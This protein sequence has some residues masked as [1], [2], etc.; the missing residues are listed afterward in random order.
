M[1]LKQDTNENQIEFENPAQ[2][3][4]RDCLL[5]AANRV[6][7]ETSIPFEQPYIKQEEVLLIKQLFG[8]NYFTPQNS[9]PQA[10]PEEASN[11]YYYEYLEKQFIHANFGFEVD[12]YTTPLLQDIYDGAQ[13]FPCLVTTARTA[14]R[15]QQ[16][17]AV[18]QLAEIE[19][20]IEDFRAV[21]YPVLPA[22]AAYRREVL[23][24]VEKTTNLPL[25]NI[26][27][28]VSKYRDFLKFNPT[29][30]KQRQELI[31]DPETLKNFDEEEGV[32]P[33]Q[34]LLDLSG[35]KTTEGAGF[36]HLGRK[37]IAATRQQDLYLTLCQNTKQ[38]RI[39]Q[40]I[41]EVRGIS[42]RVRSEVQP[43]L[44]EK[45]SQDTLEAVKGI[46]TASGLNHRTFLILLQTLEHKLDKAN[47]LGTTTRTFL[48]SL[49]RP[50]LAKAIE[51]LRCCS[52]GQL[53]QYL[54]KKG[55]DGS[56]KEHAT[57]QR[58]GGIEAV[59]LA[60]QNFV[61]EEF[62]IQDVENALHSWSKA[63]VSIETQELL[64]QTLSLLLQLKGSEREEIYSKILN[65]QQ[66][67]W[68][69][70][71]S[72]Y[73]LKLKNEDKKPEIAI[74]DE[75]VILM[76]EHLIILI[77]QA[78]HPHN[79]GD[80][81]FTAGRLENIKRYCRGQRTNLVRLRPSIIQTVETLKADIDA[82]I[83]FLYYLVD[84]ANLEGNEDILDL[85]QVF[86]EFISYDKIFEYL[87]MLMPFK[88]GS[89][90][91]RQALEEIQAQEG[92]EVAI[93]RSKMIKTGGPS[94]KQ[95]TKKEVFYYDEAYA[96]KF[97]AALSA[98]MEVTPRL[99]ALDTLTQDWLIKYI[100]NDLMGYA[101]AE[102]L[103][104]C[105][106]NTPGVISQDKY[107]SHR[108]IAN[109]SS[110]GK[111]FGAFRVKELTDHVLNITRSTG[112]QLIVLGPDFFKEYVSWL[113][114]QNKLALTPKHMEEL[115]DGML[116]YFQN[117]R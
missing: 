87:Q 19:K 6:M 53:L 83:K 99:I 74:T 36:K 111:I 44:V 102:L 93:K 89:T 71:G 78:I 101:F 70:E 96:N 5:E 30:K 9:T 54:S 14:L 21:I 72:I 35:I 107:G 117:D 37:E 8:E 52:Q 115:V 13:D 65:G 106:K 51:E 97:N 104:V 55:F 41:R 114:Q 76:G 98:G 94:K 58:V 17:Y 2:Q 85:K 11:I 81:D 75:D 18:E 56:N 109:N 80:F 24:N 77:Q 59:E 12:Y 73:K 43:I 26:W 42:G 46:I 66:N 10:K 34:E 110:Y 60:L 116:W 64:A 61:G 112:S 105:I 84:T 88:P 22:I 69:L 32:D 90:A 38:A 82:R 27:E 40:M 1:K 23:F 62:S 25:V 20:Q 63:T 45:S 91:H 108:V 68:K 50:S 48:S 4:W 92:V 29:L 113:N 49:D 95:E 100:P 79:L 103:D 67:G 39:Y 16:N 7:E 31:V 3:E 86:L 33:I 47:F 15:Y 28:Q 57:A